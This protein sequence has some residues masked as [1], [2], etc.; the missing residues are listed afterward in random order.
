MK[1]IRSGRE[2]STVFDLLG[3]KEND[4]TAALA[5]ALAKSSLFLG[6]F[7]AD[8]AGNKHNVADEGV[9]SI[10]T[11]RSGEGITDIEI[12]ID[13]SLFIVIE[14]KVGAVIPDRAQL[15]Q[16]V[17]IV[18]RHPAQQSFIVT[19]SN[20]TEEF[21][22]IKLNPPQINEVGIVHRP[23]RAIKS[24][25]STVR[26]RESNANKGLLDQF[27][28]YLEGLL[29]METRNSNMVYVV[30]L[31]QGNPTGWSLSWIDI[32]EKHRRYF[33]PIAGG[34]PDPPNYLGV[35]YGN[36]LQSIHHVERF[37]IFE[38]PRS[39]FVEAPDENWPPHY[40]LEL[41]PPIV[42]QHPVLNG[43]RIR[44]ANRCWCM[45]D[46]L[47]TSPTISDALSLTEQRRNA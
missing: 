11:S 34:W 16:Y 44:H 47:L 14:A 46:A 19:V 36:R 10:Q 8:V 1:L 13:Q 15:S 12:E 31:G 20:A 7:V 39:V 45:I 41:G 24:I 37:F 29:G 35:R 28:S 27:T 6:A 30:S 26:I 42:P 23:W 18:A 32:V 17:P 22:K 2:V 4:M 43:S 21:A 33:Y 9:I 25:A 3:S 5:F 40:C 38:N